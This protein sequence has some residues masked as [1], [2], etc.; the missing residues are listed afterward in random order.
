[1][2]RTFLAMISASVTAGAAIFASGAAAMGMPMG[3]ASGQIVKTTSYVFALDLNGVQ[4]MYTEAQ[5]KSEHPKTGEVMLFGT[6]SAMGGMTMSS[7]GVRHLGV[8]SVVRA[9]R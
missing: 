1:M 4:Q 7:S 8:H 9:E 2:S 5:V 3:C 6:M